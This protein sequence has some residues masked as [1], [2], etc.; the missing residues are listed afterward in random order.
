MSWLRRLAAKKKALPDVPAAEGPGDPRRCACGR[1]LDEAAYRID[2][3]TGQVVEQLRCRDCYE[4]L[5]ARAHRPDPPKK[6]RWM[7]H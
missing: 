7:P 6:T 2:P 5:A 4:L 1:P 3:L